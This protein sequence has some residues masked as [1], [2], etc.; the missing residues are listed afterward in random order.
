VKP[1]TFEML[2]KYLRG[3]EYS[4][5]SHEAPLLE[6]IVVL[7]WPKA[8][9]VLRVVRMHGIMGRLGL[10]PLLDPLWAHNRLIT[11]CS[12]LSAI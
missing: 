6:L 12:T 2:L 5:D 3:D 7:L 10:V 8:A 11:Q 4:T 1:N 9:I